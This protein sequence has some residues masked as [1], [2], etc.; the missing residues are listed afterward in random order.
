MMESTTNVHIENLPPAVLDLKDAL[1]DICQEVSSLREAMLGIDDLRAE[2]K[3]VRKVLEQLALALDPLRHL[4][5]MSENL[6]I[7]ARK[8]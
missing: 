7:L 8:P 4:S 1:G 5:A 2:V 3:Q 6:Y